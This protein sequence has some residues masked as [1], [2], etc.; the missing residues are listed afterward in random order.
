MENKSNFGLIAITLI[1][2]GFLPGCYSW[3]AAPEDPLCA[4][5]DAVSFEGLIKRSEK[6]LDSDFSYM[7]AED[8]ELSAVR[9]NPKKN[10]ADLPWN[11]NEALT[12]PLLLRFVWLSDVHMRQR[13]LKLGSKIFAESL[14][15]FIKSTQFNDAQADFHWAVY[16]SLILGINELHRQFPIDF[17]IHTGD[18]V[19]TGSLEELYQFIYISNKLD[20]PWLNVVGNHDLSIFG[21]YLPRLGYGRDP[22]VTFYPIGNLGDFIWMHRDKREISGIGRGLL[23]LPKNCRHVASCEYRDGNKLAATAHHGFDLYRE[24]RATTCRDKPAAIPSYDKHAGYYATDLC[25]TPIGVRLIVLNSFEKGKL[26]ADGSINEDQRNW[27]KKMIESAKGDIKLVFFHHRPHQINITNPHEMIET[28]G[29]LADH[30]DGPLV[31]FTGHT[32]EFDIEWHKKGRRNEFIEQGEE[33]SESYEQGEEESGFYELN[34]GSVL[35]FPQIGRVI[36]LRGTPRG[37]IWLISR[38][39]WSSFMT[40]REKDMPDEKTL[41]KIIDNCKNKTERKA[42]QKDLAHAVECGHYG[43]Y[44]DYLKDI[45]QWR[46]WKRGQAFDK[47]WDATNVII[48]I[49]DKEQGKR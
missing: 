17:V 39:L 6:N 1:I 38:A 40:L 43:A 24:E 34:T 3:I 11:K 33:G 7:L 46:F 4:G 9:L 14:D 47:A 10:K 28:I 21:N 41:K 30:G 16:Y 22:G 19:D 20:I 26:L 13:E 37:R 25:G 15:T 5:E 42:I 27:L 31:A 32:H 18:S 36:E 44:T 48:Q 12:A 49:K 29:L 35:E 23:A 2:F 8:F 45:R